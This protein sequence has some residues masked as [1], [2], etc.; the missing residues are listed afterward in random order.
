MKNVKVS[1]TTDL[2]LFYRPE[3]CFLF[4]LL[5][6]Q[7]FGKNWMYNSKVHDEKMQEFIFSF[8]LD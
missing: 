7:I 6:E 5:K 4:R 8:N 2:N 3:D 1:T